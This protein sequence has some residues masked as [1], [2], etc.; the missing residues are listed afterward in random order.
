VLQ[1]LAFRLAQVLV[2]VARERRNI[3]KILKLT[4][5]ASSH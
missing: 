3:F 5:F 4:F 1:P 2:P